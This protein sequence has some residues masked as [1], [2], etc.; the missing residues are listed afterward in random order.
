MYGLKSSE[1]EKQREKYGSNKLPEPK[2]KIWF[3]FT[4]EA[5]SQYVMILLIV[6]TSLQ[7]VF[8]LLGVGEFISPIITLCVIT[9]CT[10]V[11][12]KGN[13]GNQKSAMNLYRKTSVRYCDVIRDGKIQT[14]N[15]NDLVV[16]DC[17][18]LRTG[19]EFYA[20]GY[21]VEGKLTVN[22]A[23]LN[24]EPEDVKKYVTKNFVYNS[25]LKKKTL[26]ACLKPEYIL[27]CLARPR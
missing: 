7:L 14:I 21:I 18:L 17:V 26:V 8:G 20:D 23:A 5:L 15:R 11:N 13:L 19:Q 6:L 27:S 22:N 16:G 1:V 24:G 12:V 9:L 2:M 3:D 4:K 10:I 25:E